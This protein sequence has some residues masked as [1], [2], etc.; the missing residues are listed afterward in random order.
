ME[1]TLNVFELSSNYDYRAR[2]VVTGLACEHGYGAG[3]SVTR[4]NDN[5]MYCVE[6]HRGEITDEKGLVKIVGAQIWAAK[7]SELIEGTL[8]K[9][10]IGYHFGRFIDEKDA[11][12]KRTEEYNFSGNIEVTYTPVEPFDVTKQLNQKI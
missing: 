2:E 7:F 12:L 5:D 1:I 10:E 3:I 11:A 9:K 4:Q 6:I 8:R